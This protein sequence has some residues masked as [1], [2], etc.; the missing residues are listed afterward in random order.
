MDIEEIKEKVILRYP[1]LLVDRVEEIRGERI[2]AIKN[3]TIN[4][5]FFQGHFPEPHPSVTPGTMIIEGMAQVAGLL[6]G[7]KIGDEEL[8]YLVGVDNAKFKRQVTPGDQIVYRG[9]LDRSRK[10]IYRVNVEARVEDTIAA[11]ALI[12]LAYEVNG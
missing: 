6:A 5:P 2:T 11:S 3:V 4:E 12:T 1:Y 9:E 7:E 10:N 8:G